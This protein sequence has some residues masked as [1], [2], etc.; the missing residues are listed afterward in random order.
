MKINY[1][2]VL[3]DAVLACKCDAVFGRLLNK[4]SVYLRSENLRSHTIHEDTLATGS[5][6]FVLSL[7]FQDSVVNI[8]QNK[9]IF[10]NADLFFITI[11]K[12]FFVL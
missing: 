7:N 11:A 8:I 6:S 3:N 10:W 9:H 2:P 4:V 1:P 5:H 12:K